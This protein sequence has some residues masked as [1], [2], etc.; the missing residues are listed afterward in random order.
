MVAPDLRVQPPR[1]PY[2]T[3][4]GLYMLPRTIDKAQAILAGTHGAYEMA[5]LSTVLLRELAIAENEL[6]TGIRDAA[7]DAEIAVW[8]SAVQPQINVEHINARLFA[9]TSEG[10]DFERLA[11]DYYP[12]LRARPIHRWMDIALTDD[13]ITFG[14]NAGRHA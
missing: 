11:R 5:G 2:A 1:S 3:L 7:T 4:L 8:I 10:D 14:G 13:R 9:L 12:W 6:F